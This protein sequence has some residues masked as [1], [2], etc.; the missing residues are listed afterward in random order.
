[1]FRV[2]GVQWSLHG[3]QWTGALKE[4]RKA[5]AWKKLAG[6]RRADMWRSHA[7]TGDDKLLTD[8]LNLFQCANETPPCSDFSA[9]CQ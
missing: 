6:D 3:R 8:R 9:V 7:G 4:P 1:M 5:G 2:L